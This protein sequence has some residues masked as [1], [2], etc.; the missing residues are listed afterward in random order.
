MAWEEQDI[1]QMK[2]VQMAEGAGG[3][4]GTERR[5]VCFKRRSGESALARQVAVGSTQGLWDLF[6][7]RFL[8]VKSTVEP[9]YVFK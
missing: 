4:Q 7:K 6:R 1:R 2:H 8:N 9:F 5:P 3:I